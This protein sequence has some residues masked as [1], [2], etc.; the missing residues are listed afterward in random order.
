MSGP[1]WTVVTMTPIPR[2][3]SGAADSTRIA[4]TLVYVL[5]I[6]GGSTSC[7][8][9]RIRKRRKQIIAVTMMFKLTLSEIHGTTVLS[10]PLRR[11][12]G[13]RAIFTTVTIESTAK[14]KSQWLDIESLQ[15]PQADRITSVPEVARYI[16]TG[17][18]IICHREP[19]IM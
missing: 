4:A 19:H 16:I 17:S 9:A 2:I 14:K 7:I 12:E 8:R 3:E 13:G 6:S 15:P 11:Y 5:D 1:F 18:T 10:L